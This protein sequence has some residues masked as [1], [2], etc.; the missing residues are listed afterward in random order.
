[1]GTRIVNGACRVVMTLFEEF[2][3]SKKEGSSSS[4]VDSGVS[5]AMPP[6]V[7]STP[8]S[9]SGSSGEELPFGHVDTASMIQGHSQEPLA[10][11]RV[12][13]YET[14]QL[15]TLEPN[16]VYSINEGESGLNAYPDNTLLT[17]Q[18]PEA[19]YVSDSLIKDIEEELSKSSSQ[20]GNIAFPFPEYFEGFSP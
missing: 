12:Q 7:T 13:P 20:Q 14:D 19:S 8:T 2:N 5:E 6:L 4:G 11:L 9:S 1:M 18:D 10:C 17:E 3:N 15:H 16:L